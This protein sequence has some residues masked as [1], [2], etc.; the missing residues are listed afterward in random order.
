MHCRLDGPAAYQVLDNFEQRW[1]EEKEEAAPVGSARIREE[2]A[3]EGG[4]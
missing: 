1:R 4:I 2:A 3:L